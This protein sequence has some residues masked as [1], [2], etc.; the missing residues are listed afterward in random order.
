MDKTNELPVLLS[1]EVI[2]GTCK[3]LVKKMICF[4]LCREIITFYSAVHEIHK[5]SLN[6]SCYSKYHLL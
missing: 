2:V 1:D 3:I 4:L 5:Q 6:P